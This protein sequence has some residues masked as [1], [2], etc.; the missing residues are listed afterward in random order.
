MGRARGRGNFLRNLILD[1]SHVAEANYY[2][3]NEIIIAE[4]KQN[5]ENIASQIKWMGLISV[6]V[7][8]FL[9]GTIYLIKKKVVERLILLNKSVLESINNNSVNIDVTGKDEITD[10]ARSFIYFSEKVALQKQQLQ[11]LSLTD[12]LTTLSNRRALDER[13]EYDLK[14]SKR[15][16]WPLSAILLDIDHFKLYNDYYGHIPGDECLQKIANCLKNIKQRD[17]D[18]IGRYG[19]EEFVMLLPDTDALGALK[20]SKRIVEAIQALNIT[21]VKSDVA[22]HVTVSVGAATFS[23]AENI[24]IDSMLMKTDQALY[25]AKSHGRNCSYHANDII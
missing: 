17:S 23:C 9:F 21:H 25:Y 16:Q 12:G 22:D 15:S 13:L 10:L 8:F 24:S 1:I 4:T 14:T 2:R 7:V 18:F 3:I 19:G 20:V 11:T 5:T 6:F